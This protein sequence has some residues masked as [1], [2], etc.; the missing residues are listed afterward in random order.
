MLNSVEL[1]RLNFV[2]RIRSDLMTA[3]K[4]GILG[5]SYVSN[6]QSLGI[7]SGKL[8]GGR[9]YEIK[10]FHRSGSCFDFWLGWPHQLHEC[11][12][13][14]PDYLIVI[15]GGNSIKESIRVKTLKEKAN[16]FFQVLRN[17]LPDTKLI[18]A[19][20]ELRFLEK[21]NSFGT[22]PLQRYRL[23]RNKLNKALQESKIKDFLLCIAGNTR[24]DNI[25]YY[26]SDRIHLNSSG[27]QFLL[28]LIL[29]K[30][31]SILNLNKE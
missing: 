24:L 15:L 10:Y 7:T 26:R 22:P 5:H 11:V 2:D 23:I 16:I 14:K 18:P 29:R 1:L 17:N 8:Q 20:I 13:F 4:I 9:N 6:L 28:R 27:L 25:K 30:I 3:I 19:Q 12:E 31:E 21:T